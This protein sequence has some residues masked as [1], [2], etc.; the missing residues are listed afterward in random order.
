MSPKRK[1]GAASKP[2]AQPKPSATTGKA[3]APPTPAPVP[4]KP[5]QAPPAA[6]A[7]PT[8]QRVSPP[9]NAGPSRSGVTIQPNP[10]APPPRALAQPPKPSAQPTRSAFA[11][12]LRSAPVP[13]HNAAPA[14]KVGSSQKHAFTLSDRV[15]AQ[16]IEFEASWVSPRQKQIEQ[17]LSELFK[18]AERTAH[19][20][21]KLR[22]DG[23]P[24]G[25]DKIVNSMQREFALAARAE[26]DARLDRAGLQAE[27]WS[28]ITPQ[29]MLAVEQ[30]L[31][32]D[33]SYDEPGVYAQVQHGAFATVGSSGS[34]ATDTTPPTV[35]R[36]L[37]GWSSRAPQKTHESRPLQNTQTVAARHATMTEDEPTKPAHT[38]GS[39]ST[40]IDDYSRAQPKSSPPGVLIT[41]SASTSSRVSQSAA[42]PAPASIPVSTTT[43]LLVYA[44]PV[45][46][47]QPPLDSALAA[48]AEYMSVV[49]K[50]Y[51]NSIRQFHLKAAEADVELA[52]QLR[53]SMPAADRDFTVRAHIVAMEQS[54]RDIVTRRNQLLDDERKKR[55]LG[56]HRGPSGDSAPPPPA[57]VQHPARPVVVPGAF[58]EERVR[59]AR[60]PEPEPEPLLEYIGET[61]P[62]PEPEPEADVDEVIEIPIKGKGKGKGKTK[63]AAVEAKPATNGRST[64]TPAVPKSA[65]KVVTPIPTSAAKAT[66]ASDTKVSANGRNSPASGASSTSGLSP[67]EILQAKA[68]SGSSDTADAKVAASQNGMWAPPV[69]RGG[70]NGKNPFAPTRPSRLA[71]VTQVPE[72]DPV[73][74]SPESPEPPSPP[75]HEPSGRDYVAWFAGSSSEDDESM[76]G[77]P[78]DEDEDDDDGEETEAGGSAGFGGLLA[79]LAGASPWAL[80][81][82]SSQPQKARPASPARRGG[83]TPTPARAP[84]AEPAYARWAVPSSG[85]SGFS[86][87]PSAAPGM[88][89]KA[90]DRDDDADLD[91]MLE[92]ASSTLGKAAMGGSRSGGVN[93]E[94]AM[95]MY[96]TASKARE[97]LV[98]PVGGRSERRR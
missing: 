87:G 77:D 3:P 43:D 97:T 72:S 22:A 69:A 21:G 44:V 63:K 11:S 23:T 26:W 54:A 32:Y 98:T 39:K 6:S 41:P 52:R 74:A 40:P 5:A 12:H 9:P 4:Q 46:L 61:V 16:W 35:P 30:V 84:P 51:I 17:E 1:N 81:G 10:V 64:P 76:S 86:A 34:I 80:F 82:E 47:T 38:W 8:S 33:E 15:R 31:S 95:A 13:S 96:V 92:I 48:N 28:D 85:P 58:P 65:P 68:A 42:K 78:L 19:A 53:K 25:M 94:E 18:V 55:G 27:D 88:W 67:W 70:S 20:K 36:A 2:P 89:K 73:P 93:I 14:A 90:D 49:E 66:S 62:E 71:Q 79:S 91:N 24:D 75:A 59:P 29:E 57:T 60:R 7:P 37:S 45:A 50:L 83:A 56:D